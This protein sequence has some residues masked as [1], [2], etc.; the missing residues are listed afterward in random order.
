MSNVYTLYFNQKY[1]RSGPLFA[2]R[3]KATQIPN[4]ILTSLLRSIHTEPTNFSSYNDYCCQEV[5]LPCSKNIKDQ[6]LSKFPNPSKFVEYHQ[7]QMG[8]AVTHE[9]VKPFLIENR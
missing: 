1:Q 5:L 8:I 3:F 7:S 4:D 2:G 9:K 6:V